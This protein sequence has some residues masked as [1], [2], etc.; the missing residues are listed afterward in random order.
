MCATPVQLPRKPTDRAGLSANQSPGS[1]DQATL[2]AHRSN[3]T[4]HMPAP[5]R[6]VRNVGA[7]GTSP[8]NPYGNGGV[9]MMDQHN[10]PVNPG[11]G[12]AT[13][14]V[15]IGLVLLAVLVA[16]AYLVA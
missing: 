11:V 12:H 8:R 10:Q 5:I 1:D 15:G 4:S 2:A 14:I 9:Q 13:V 6:T 16:I 7:A 3:N